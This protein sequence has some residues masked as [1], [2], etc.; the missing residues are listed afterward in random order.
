MRSQ[1]FSALASLTPPLP[2]WFD[3][4]LLPWFRAA[5]DGWIATIGMYLNLAKAPWDQE[6]TKDSPFIFEWKTRNTTIAFVIPA[7]SL[8]EQPPQSTMEKGTASLGVFVWNMEV[9]LKS[10]G[11]KIERTRWSTYWNVMVKTVQNGK[12]HEMSFLDLFR[13]FST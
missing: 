8:S 6:S 10:P 9:I 1:C 13:L 5:C 2:P 11:D 4:V 7:I 3:H 12:R